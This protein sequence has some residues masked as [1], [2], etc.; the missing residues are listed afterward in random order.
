MDR[1]FNKKR[2]K[3]PK[4]PQQLGVST[5]TVAGPGFLAKTDIDLKGDQDYSYQDLEVDRVDLTTMLGER[6]SRGTRI[7][8]QDKS[9]GGQDLPAPEAS[10]SGVIDTG[11]GR[12]NDPKNEGFRS[13]S[14]GPILT[15]PFFSSLDEDIGDTGGGESEPAEASR[16]TCRR[17]Y[18]V[19]FL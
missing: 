1:I 13:L 19:D 7:V 4:P 12:G 5:N 15:S 3:S 10:T 17:R 6:G 16:G 14:F 8:S 11:I 2:K 18:C 9:G